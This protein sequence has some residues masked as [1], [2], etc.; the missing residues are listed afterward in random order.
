MEEKRVEMQ[1]EFDSKKPKIDYQKILGLLSGQTS[2][3]GST[4][5]GM[6][7]VNVTT[8]ISRQIDE[9]IRLLQDQ[10]RKDLTVVNTNDLTI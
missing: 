1:E 4:G 8:T 7:E 6:G 9:V 5:F 3:F 10:L 2:G